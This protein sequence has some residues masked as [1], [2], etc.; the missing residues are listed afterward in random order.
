[1]PR[2]TFLARAAFSHLLNE[3]SLGGI[4]LPLFPSLSLA[5]I[6]FFLFCF[7]FVF[8]IIYS[9]VSCLLV[10]S[11]INWKKPGFHVMTCQ[12]DEI[13]CCIS[14]Y[15]YFPSLTWSLYLDS[16]LSNVLTS[17]LSTTGRFPSEPL[18]C[19][20]SPH[21]PSF[22][23]PAPPRPSLPNC[24]PHNQPSSLSYEVP[25][26]PLLT[27]TP[28]SSSLFTVSLPMSSQ[29]FSPIP[30]RSLSFSFSLPP[31]GVP[32]PYSFSSDHH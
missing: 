17:H 4:L 27:S 9:S 31:L 12:T 23:P 15:N 20:L 19:G 18:P 1:M 16:L 26:L 5:Y 29:F 10:N 6:L 14:Y 28:T 22:P 7:F 25:L 2:A 13:E 32:C 8:L 24:S 21:L 30:L 11:I 3:K